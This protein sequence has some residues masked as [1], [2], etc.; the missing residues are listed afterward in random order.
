GAQSGET[1][2]V[3]SGNRKLSGVEVKGYTANVVTMLN[4]D[5]ETGRFFSPTEERHA[6]PVAIIGADIK[7][8]IFP[9]LDPVNRTIFVHGYPMRVIG[10]QKR[11]GKMLGQAR[12][13]VIFV[14]ITFLTKVLSSDRGLAILVRQRG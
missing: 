8:E 4:L 14:P 13:K 1:A 11:L 9:S 5:L 3:K 12:D 7:D 2:A 6:A 10:V